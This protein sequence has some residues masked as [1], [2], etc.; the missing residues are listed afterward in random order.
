M[1]SANKWLRQLV[2][3]IKTKGGKPLAHPVTGEDVTPSSLKQL[4]YGRGPQDSLESSKERNEYFSIYT[5]LFPDLAR[6][7]AYSLAQKSKDML[8]N[9]RASQVLTA[10]SRH[11]DTAAAA[12][13]KLAPV[14]GSSLAR[15]RRLDGKLKLGAGVLL[16]CND[17]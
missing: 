6:A 13:M 9:A 15:I 8:E 7:H 16:C 14:M 12:L 2:C 1:A 17:R 3:E 4:K 11:V 5:A 10:T